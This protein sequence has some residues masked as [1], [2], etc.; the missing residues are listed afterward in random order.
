MRKR[1]CPECG[2]TEHSDHR[3]FNCPRCYSTGHLYRML[4]IDE[5]AA[6]IERE[7]AAGFVDYAEKRQAIYD[8]VIA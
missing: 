2:H 3:M 8:R 1:V 6:S 5:L 4:T 7:R